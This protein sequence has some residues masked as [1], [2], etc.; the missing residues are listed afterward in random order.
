MRAAFLSRTGD[1]FVIQWG[2]LAD[3]VPG[4]GQ[5]R[6]R[7]LAVAVDA[8]DALVR[9]GRWS[10]PLAFPV[11]VGRDLVGAVDGLGPGVSGLREGDRVWTSS[12]GYAGRPGAT[13]ELVV[14]D[15]DR[16]YPVPDAADP[17]AFSSSSSSPI[18]R[19]SERP[20]GGGAT[21]HSAGR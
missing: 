3:P 9:S 1:P 8:V 20:V 16:V 18:G 10:T 15:A 11:A 7:A 13:A 14:V 4:P 2:E 17:V 21:P 12:A 19:T 6:V 5:V